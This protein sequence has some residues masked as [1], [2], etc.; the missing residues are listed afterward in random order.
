M[1]RYKGI[2]KKDKVQFIIFANEKDVEVEIP[3]ED[4]IAHRFSLYL[5]KIAIPQ[6]KPVERQNDEP[7]E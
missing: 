5:D 4:H 1:I 6:S 7:S 2:K 3:L